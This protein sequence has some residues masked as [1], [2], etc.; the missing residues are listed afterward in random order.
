MWQAGDHRARIVQVN[1]SRVFAR[2]FNS[3]R[4]YELQ[5]TDFTKE[6]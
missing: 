3:G 4:R 5:R 1:R 6:V 2:S